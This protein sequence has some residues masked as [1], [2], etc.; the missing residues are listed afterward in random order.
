LI[1]L[2]IILALWFDP[3]ERFIRGKSNAY[4]VARLLND[5]GYL[6]SRDVVLSTHPEQGP[7][8]RYYIGPGPR[9]ADAFGPVP[10]PQI[11]D[12]RDAQKRLQATGPVRVL[13]SIAPTIAPGQRLIL[14]MPIIRS[15]V[16]NAPW[17][18]LVRRRT[19]QWERAVNR[20]RR[21]VRIAPVPQFGRDG[22]PRGVRAVV[23][24][25]R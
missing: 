22:L 19:M 17:T 24:L 15:S 14:V 12:W 2:A 5:G 13:R 25:R 23:Y 7:L 4:R 18:S 11:F 1:A 16:W 21:F 8:L 6:T 3:R 20:D 10:D 9:Y